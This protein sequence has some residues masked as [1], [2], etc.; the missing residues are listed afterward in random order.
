MNDI[1]RLL[2]I[3]VL[4]MCASVAYMKADCCGGTNCCSSNTCCNNCDCCDN[5]CGCMGGKYSNKTFF[6]DYINFFQSGT[7]M[8][9]ALFPSSRMTMRDEGWGGAIQLVPFGGRTSEDG[10]KDLGRWFGLNHS[11]S[12]VAVEEATV[13]APHNVVMTTEGAALDVRHFNV[14]TVNGN[15]NSTI[16]FCPEQKFAGIG[17]DWKQALWR[18]DDDSARW[19]ME[20]SGPVLH[21]KNSMCMKENVTADGGGVAA[22]TSALDASPRV[23]NM[24]EAFKQ[25]NWKYGKIVACGTSCC[26]TTTTTTTNTCGCN[27]GCECACDCCCDMEKTALAF[28]ELKL[29]YNE[30]ITECCGLGSYI[31]V[32]FPT[33]KEACPGMVFSPMVGGKHW[34]IM[35]GSEIGFTMWS[36]DDA[37]IRARFTIDGRY[38]FRRDE[39]RS[40][41]LVGKPWSRYMEMYEN[42]AAAAAGTPYSGTSGINLMT[43]CVQVTPRGQVNINTGI[44]YEGKCFK[45]EIGHTWYG[46]QAEKIC[47]N[48]NFADTEYPV[49][50][51]YAASGDVAK[52]RTIRDR[53]VGVPDV[54]NQ[55]P[56]FSYN[57][58]VYAGGSTAYN[59]YKITKCDVD[60]NS[61]AHEAVLAHTIYGTLGYDW[62]DACYPTIVTVGGAYDFAESNAS[63]R[64]WTIFGKL[65]VSF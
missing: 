3:A 4:F 24:T 25:S 56:D 37:A 23:A 60:W 35:W 43:R 58:A 42:Q 8:H 5:Y 21:V 45:A 16:T 20:L 65:G 40:F 26:G 9:E 47:P 53:F 14:Q 41:D 18:N 28:L 49:L 11:S 2:L 50:K 7:Y 48:W 19:W 46:R 62:S 32:V 29:G 54:I 59:L 63:M 13:A 27:C 6:A 38:L 15:F 52:A 22:V 36:N 61:A 44:A 64:R 39:M 51:S 12:L 34:G 30:V 33:G 1:K 31:G 57:F 17:L 10:R 55:G